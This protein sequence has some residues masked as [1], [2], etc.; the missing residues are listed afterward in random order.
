MTVRDASLTA[1][2]AQIAV[3]AGSLAV[4][5]DGRATGTLDISLRKAPTA[6]TAM[7]ETGI[8]PPE[9]AAA[10]ALVVG[11]RQGDGDV[12][13]AQLTFQAGQTTLGP[14]AVGPAPRVFTR[15]AP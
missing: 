15:P 6:L 11:A 9:T 7:G 2:E 4:G 1:G 3:K 14:V 8:L 10:A 12:A 5:P 13:R